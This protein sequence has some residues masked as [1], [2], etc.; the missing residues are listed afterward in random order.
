MEGTPQR[1]VYDS[2][3]ILQRRPVITA[4]AVTEDGQRAFLGLD[5]GLLEEYAVERVNETVKVSLTAR[6]PV[7]FKVSLI[8]SCSKVSISVYMQ[9]SACVSCSNPYYLYYQQLEP[10]VSYYKLEMGR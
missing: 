7:V 3:L 6:K 10:T 8:M 2:G 9:H 5:G 1:R 4:V